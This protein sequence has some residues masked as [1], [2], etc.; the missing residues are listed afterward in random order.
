[1]VAQARA[2]GWTSDEHFT[3]DGTLL[4]A[5][6]SVRVY[7]ARTRRVSRR[8]TIQEIP[9][10][11]FVGKS[12]ERDARIEDGSEAMLARKSE[13]KEAKLSYSGNVLVENRHGLMWPAREGSH[14]N[15]RTRRRA[16][17]AAGSPRTGARR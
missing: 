7:S 12:A 11:I 6:A 3:V 5:W 10:W 9:R 16:G 17:D 2:K 15:R 1:M 14:R 4:E 8:R 13:G